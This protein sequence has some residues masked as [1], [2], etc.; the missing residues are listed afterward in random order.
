VILG[1]SGGSR[2]DKRIILTSIFIPSPKIFHP[3]AE[4]IG[5]I[6]INVTTAQIDMAIRA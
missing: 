2:E 5:R 1:K 4:E 3:S 6:C